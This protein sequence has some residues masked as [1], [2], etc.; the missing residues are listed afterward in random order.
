MNDHTGQDQS[1]ENGTDILGWVDGLKFNRFHVVLVVLASLPVLFGGYCTQVIALALPSVLKEW[2]LSSMSAGTLVSWGFFGFML[3]SFFFGAI[4]DRMGRKKMLMVTLALCSVSTG[5]S[6]YASNFEM[7]CVLRF[8]TGLGVGGVFPLS[9]A[10]TSEFA[11]LSLRAR[12]LTIVAGSYTF[13]WAVAAFVSIYLIPAFGWRM[14]FAAGALPLI[15]LPFMGLYLPESIRFL[16]GKT[17]HTSRFFMRG[18]A[19]SVMYISKEVSRISRLGRTALP[20]GPVRIP[21]DS[22]KP[23]IGSISS[24]FGPGFIRMTILLSL[25]YLLCAIVLYGISSWLPALMIKAGFSMTKSFSYSMVQSIGSC[26]GGIFL[27]YLLDIFGRK[28]GLA[29]TYLLGGISVLLF[30]FVSSPASLYIVGAATGVFVLAAP[31]A[32]LVVCGETYPTNIRST[33][34]G[35]VQ[36]ISKIGSILGPI[37]GGALQVLNFGLE[38][39]FTFFALPCFVCI[40]LVL[41]YRTKKKGET[42][43]N[44]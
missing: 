5:L 22:S 23:A 26:L 4:A 7:F 31:T 38:Q 10:L 1:R 13:G 39:F 44:I 36:G 34:V 32:L 25:T 14:M 37:V 35:L 42:L 43:Q 29:L 2:G 18:S 11:P 27:G 12:L 19:D 41:F 30:G 28:W 20:V 40:V 6:Y 17:H 3:G 21:I 16:Y 9:V 15:C 24:L 33:G 8:C